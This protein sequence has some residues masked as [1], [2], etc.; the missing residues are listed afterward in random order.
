MK[1]L[2]FFRSLRR[3][4][5][6]VVFGLAGLLVLSA[7]SAGEE[8]K[9]GSELDAATK[10][11]MESTAQKLYQMAATGNTSALQQNSIPAVA[12]NFAGIESAINEHKGDFGTS[13]TVR[14]SYGLDAPGAA[15]IARAEFYCGIFNSPDRVAFVIPNLP[16]GNYGVVILD[17]QGGKI[18]MSV[19]FVLQKDAAGQWKLGGFY[20]RYTSISGHDGNW[21]LNQARAYKAKG[22]SH[23][24]WLYY[25]AAWDLSAPVPFMSTAGLDRI[26]E[27]AQG[28]R[29]ADFPSQDTPLPLTSANG[30]TYNVIQLFAVPMQDG[31]GLVV[32]FQVPDISNSAQ[33][34][35][36]N[37]AVMKD[38]VTRYPELREAFGSIVARAVA[39]SGQDY[40]TLLAMK[41]VK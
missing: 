17:A 22:Q 33:T 3:K 16:P 27:E 19:S 37:M 20:P 8:C 15:P 13:A 10:S 6:V 36:D 26:G 18:P 25:L 9:M 24:A 4:V 31:L 40:G 14:A 7:L 1:S 23:D 21:Y 12:S 30:K 11:A 35:Q 32:K 5:N 38:L 41:D 34:Y 28:V 39:P 29:P 2:N